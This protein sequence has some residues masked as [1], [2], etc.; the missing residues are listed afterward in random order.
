MI[1]ETSE[2]PPT[3]ILRALNT[4][5]TRPPEAVSSW[6]VKDLC[7]PLARNHFLLPGVSFGMD[8]G[9]IPRDWELLEGRDPS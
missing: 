6:G 5:R 9:R 4:G 7:L 2:L 1:L 3:Q 8:G